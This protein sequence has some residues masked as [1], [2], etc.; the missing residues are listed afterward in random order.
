MKTTDANG[1]VTANEA[2][3]YDNFGNVVKEIDY[4]TN[5]ITLYS[6]GDAGEVTTSQELLG[7]DVNSQN[8]EETALMV[9]DENTT[10]TSDGDELTEELEEGTVEENS[11]YFYDE[12]GNV[13]LEVTS[14]TDIGEELLQKLSK[15]DI[16]VEEIK[17]L[18]IG[19]DIVVMLYEYDDFLR[20]VKTIEISKKV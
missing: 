9:S 16:K 19:T 6:Y 18:I 14:S 11:A 10:Y 5:V 8:F 2:Y 4:I 13:T 7:K 15:K 12:I 3:E 20:T 1:V 17:E